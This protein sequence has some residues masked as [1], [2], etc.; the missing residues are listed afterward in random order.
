V[1]EKLIARCRL[2]VEGKAKGLVRTIA[3]MFVRL[4]W[5]FGELGEGFQWGL[6]LNIKPNTVRI[7]RYVYIGAN[8]NIGTPLVVGDLCMIS[9]NFHLIGNDHNAGI[10]G[11]PTRLGFRREKKVTIIESD[12]WIGHG[13]TMLSG[14][15]I[16]RGSIIAAG[17]VVTKSVPPYSIVGGVPAKELRMRF[18]PDQIAVHDNEIYGSIQE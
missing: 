2:E 11:T 9:T 16:G 12:C 6:P 1:S 5:K 18:S 13:V 15:V 14:V 3:V 7:G 17:A 8:A 4:I 10:I